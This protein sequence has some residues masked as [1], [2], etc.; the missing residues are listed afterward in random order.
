MQSY[1]AHRM[2]DPLRRVLV[3]RPAWDP[4]GLDGQDWAAWG[5]DGPPDLDEAQREHDGLVAAL[6][7][8][9]A[10]VEVLDYPHPTLYDSIFPFDPAI[11]TRHGAVLLPS[12]KAL[13]QPEVAPM[14]RRLLELRIPIL[15]TLAGEATADGGDTLWLDEN[16]LVV[17]RSYR[18]NDAAV[19]QLRTVLGQFGIRVETVD[20]PHWEGR[21]VVMHL[22]SLISLVDQDLAVGYPKLL[23]VRLVEWLDARSVELV[24]V[25]DEEFLTLGPNVLALGPRRCLVLAGNPGTRRALERA[26]ASV[27]EYQGRQLSLKMGGGPTCLTLPLYRG[28]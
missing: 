27:V 6:R 24:P 23:P 11:V 21:S 9:G 3:R 19:A 10:R 7:A 25:P 1:G 13:R 15:Y 4:A 16:T 2:A 18:T 5:Y 22:L 28:E 12:G 26:G 17:G 14:G 20:V 8:A